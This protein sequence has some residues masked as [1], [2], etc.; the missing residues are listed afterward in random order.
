MRVSVYTK[1]PR[2]MIMIF[3]IFSQ[4]RFNF[5]HATDIFIKMCNGMGSVVVWTCHSSIDTQPERCWELDKETPQCRIYDAMVWCNIYNHTTVVW[6]WYI[7]QWI[8]VPN[9]GTLLAETWR[10]VSFKAQL[11]LLSSPCESIAENWRL[12]FR[13]PV[14][15]MASKQ[16]IRSLSWKTSSLGTSGTV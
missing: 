16:G 14:V 12:F 9:K 5:L 6:I 10:V 4:C 3:S 7:L 11:R 2:N 8:K 13:F 15:R 1:F